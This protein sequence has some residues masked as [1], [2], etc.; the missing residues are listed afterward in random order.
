MTRVAD[1]GTVDLS[2]FTSGG[3][4]LVRRG[5]RE[6]T[7]PGQWAWGETVAPTSTTG[8]AAGKSA[9]PVEGGAPTS[10]TGE[11]AGKSAAP[12]EGGAGAEA[13]AA[14]VERASVDVL[15]DSLREDMRV[16]R[17]S[18]RELVDVLRVRPEGAALATELASTSTPP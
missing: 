3:G 17:D 8:E 14:G 15:A 5:V 6:G 11:A 7:E 16:M 10:S 12:V 1:D 18:I 2:I 4:L 13:F 9:A